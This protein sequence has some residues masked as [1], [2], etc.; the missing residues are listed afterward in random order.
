MVSGGFIRYLI[1]RLQTGYNVDG[2]KYDV[3]EKTHGNVTVA[4]AVRHL[5]YMSDWCLMSAESSH[6]Q[7]KKK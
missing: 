1:H 6:R 3:Y 7:L 4:Y 5:K 2:I